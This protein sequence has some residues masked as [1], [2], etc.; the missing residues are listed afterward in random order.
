MLSNVLLVL[1]STA[2]LVSGQYSAT[3]DPNS[4]DIN[5]RRYWCSAQTSTCPLL[6]LQISSGVPE[7][8]NCTAENLSYYC[9][10][11]NGISPNSSEYSQTLPYFTCTE[12]NNQCVAECTNSACQ[13]DCR[14]NHPCGAQNPPRVNVTTTTT[15]ASMAATSTSASTAVP[16][17]EATGAASRSYVAEMGQVYGLCVLV[18]GVV[19]G[20]AVLL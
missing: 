6:C 11:S 18:G 14:T 1:A 13:S 7:A 19:A 15:S 8:N 4:V 16:S 12:A 5:T 9:I 10:C 20:F 2:A 3:I 17:K